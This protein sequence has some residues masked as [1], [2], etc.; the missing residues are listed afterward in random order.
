MVGVGLRG[1]VGIFLL[2]VK[3]VLAD[4]GAEAA[5]G[6]IKDGNSD[7]KSAE[8]YSCN[9]AHKNLKILLAADERR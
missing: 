5:A 3:R 4:A 8:V 7:A 2:A 1:V 9:D 6:G